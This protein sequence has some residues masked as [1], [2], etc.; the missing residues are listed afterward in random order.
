[1]QQ[2]CWS[3]THVLNVYVERQGEDWARLGQT[4]GDWL[5]SSTLRIKAESRVCVRL[6]SSQDNTHTGKYNSEQTTTV[7]FSNVVWHVCVL[8]GV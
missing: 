2:N 5:Y 4:S 3:I 6:L 7:L 8:H 1:M